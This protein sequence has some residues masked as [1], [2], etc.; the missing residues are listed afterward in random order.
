[1]PHTVEQLRRGVADF[2]SLLDQAAVGFAWHWLILPWLVEEQ[3]RHD[4]TV[5]GPGIAMD[6]IGNATVESS[7][8]SIRA[9]DEF[10]DPREGRS[11]DIRSHHYVG[12]R[13]PGRFLEKQEFDTI[14]RRIAHLTLD[15]A[16]DETTP[17]QITE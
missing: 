12:Y 16:D 13:S 8:I 7:L 3:K 6:V 4:Q 2:C 10:F 1:M 9:L 15:R 14:G 17:W 11:N 5:K